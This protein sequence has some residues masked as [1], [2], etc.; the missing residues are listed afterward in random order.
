MITAIGERM[1]IGTIFVQQPV[2]TFGYDNS[3]RPEPLRDHE[4][5]GLHK[6][7]MI[8]YPMIVNYRNAGTMFSENVLWL[9]N[10]QID[11]NMYID[12]VHY[13][14]QFNLDIAK[15]ISNFLLLKYPNYLSEHWQQ[16]K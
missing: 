15:R 4:K 14:P 11:Q 8:G 9:E 2:P 7:S 16:K 5:F 3:R 1:G 13:S 10:A 12:L 6:N